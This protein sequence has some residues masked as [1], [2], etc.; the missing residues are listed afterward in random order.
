[1]DEEKEDYANFLIEKEEHRRKY[2]R[3]YMKKRYS[4]N[5]QHK[6]YMK[7][8]LKAYKKKDD[9][10]ILEVITPPEVKASQE[11]DLDLK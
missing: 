3:D 6:E 4:E 10:E 9:K 1:M 7:N 11:W 8:Y 5:P 2:M